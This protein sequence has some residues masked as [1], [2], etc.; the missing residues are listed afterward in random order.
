MRPFI[1][2]F[3]V[4]LA[5]I[6]CNGQETREDQGKEQ[7]RAESPKP[8]ESWK[9]DKEVDENGNIIRMDSTYTWSFSS[10]GKDISPET[11]DSLMGHFRQRFRSGFPDM[12]NEDPFDHF[13]SDSVFSHPFFND[14]LFI[15]QWKD[16]HKQLENMM[17]Q[18]DSLHRNSLDDS[19]KKTHKI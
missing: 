3:T 10:D 6:S 9:V 5:V 4:L 11:I 18:A 7:A 14:S 13:A 15:K 12:F 1:F 19:S 2:L 8:K 16:R 17:R